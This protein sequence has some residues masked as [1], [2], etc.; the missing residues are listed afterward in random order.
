VDGDG[1]GSVTHW[2]ETLKAGDPVAAQRLWERYFQRLVRLARG[3]FPIRHKAGVIEDEEDAAVSAFKS[4]CLGLAQGRYPNLAG[5]DDLWRLLVLIAARKAVNQAE[6][7]GRQKRGGGSLVRESDM[8]AAGNDQEPRGLDE[9]LGPAPTPE[10]L[11]IMAEECQRLMGVLG[12]PDLH[13]AEIATWR[14]EGFNR[15][16]IAERLG[17]SR[18]TVA[19]RLGLIR[20]TWEQFL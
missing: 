17:C 6:R 11:A 9:L 4:V 14:L 19:S 13:L 8:R 20:K 10:F 2:I 12:Q 5:R 1:A 18:R 16:E 15:D 7:W 3:R